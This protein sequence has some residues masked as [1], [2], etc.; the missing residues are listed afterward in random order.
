MARNAFGDEIV[1]AQPVGVNAF[2]DPVLGATPAVGRRAQDLGDA[3]ISGL[4]NSATGLAVRGKLP[5]QQLGEDAPWYHRLASGGAGIVADL[6]LSVAGAAVGAAVGSGVA[7]G[8]G[9][10]VGGGAGAFAAPMAL[11]DALIEAYTYNHALSWEGV[12][13]IGKAA[14][15]G[16]LK[17]AA[18]GGATAG[19]GR[20]VAPLVAGGPVAKGVAAAGAE[21]ATLTATSAALEGHMPTWQDF[22]DNAVLLG[23]MKAAVGTAMKLRSIYAETGKRPE[24][25]FGDAQRDPKL[26]AELAEI[27][28][29][30]V[31]ETYRALAL[32]QRIKA[33]VDADQTT[34]AIR[35][36]LAPE[37]K[38]PP[39]TGESKKEPVAWEYVVDNATLKGVIREVSA[40]TETQIKEQTRGVVTNKMSQAEALKNIATGEVFQHMTGEAG[41]SAQILTAAMLLKSAANKVVLERNKIKDIPEAELALRPDL[42][43]G[44]LAAIENMAMVNA[45]FAGIRAEAGRALQILRAVKSD[46]S[47]VVQADALLKAAERKGTFQDLLAA[48]DSLKDPAQ[49]ARFAKGYT[50]ATT[51]Q[52]FIEA[53]RAGLFSGPV[54]WQANV[55]GNTAK[56]AVDTVKAPIA[57]GVEGVS[58]AAQGDPLSMAQLKARAFAPWYGLQLAAL[59]GAHLAGQWNKIAQEKGAIAGAKAVK[60]DISAFLE[61]GDAKM[62]ITQRAN[63]GA[64][65]SFVGF[66]FGMLKLQDLPFRTVGERAKAYVMAVDRVSAE[67]LHPNS[68]EFREAVARYVDNPTLG[69]SEKA[70]AK[71]LSKIERAGSEAVFSEQLGPRTAQVSG[72]MSGTPWEFIFPARRTPVNLL[73]WAVQHTPGLN[74]MS[75]RWREDYK[76]GGERRAAATA[77]VVVGT[78]L[79]ATAFQMAQDGSLTGGGLFDKEMAGTKAGAKVQNYS[80][81]VGDTYYSIQR[82]EPV[83]K[84]LMLTAD[85]VEITKSSKVEEDKKKAAAM[86]A[87]AFANATVSTTYLSGLANVMKAATDPDRYGEQFVESY[88]TTIV[89]KTIGQ[90]APLLDPY[91]REVDGVMDAIQSQIPFLREKLLPKR[92]VWGEPQSNDR[93]FD[94]MPI[95]TTEASKEKVRTEALRLQIGIADAPRYVEERGPFKSRDRRTELTPEQRDI[96]RDVSG[97][98]AM[99]ILGPIVNAPDWERIPDFAQIA[100]YKRVIQDARKQ[101]Q[102]KA[103]PPDSAE[104]QA[105]IQKNVER[106]IKE[107][108]EAETRS[109]APQRE[110]IYVPQSERRVR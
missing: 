68:R 78:A 92:D 77:R 55:L 62:D 80:I 90:T 37:T 35:R 27:A 30:D 83:A 105:V 52:K 81:R 23:G 4:Q 19:A 8:A 18:I 97:K 3:I 63:T 71:V 26:K 39:Q 107:T 48:V 31:P 65:G 75:T 36:N 61:H 102:N 6:P 56:W 2:G 49:M 88:A 43:L 58:R 91:K 76:A 15:K 50:E 38:E 54:T 10:V 42:K 69:L 9:T 47:M 87:L 109:P 59:D 29:G 57:A 103:L 41:N 51:F 1:E 86:L 99:A 98:Q 104:R 33:A 46:P 64:V 28:S 11:R 44:V 22:M 110:T 82:I 60:G 45:E 79:A 40:L 14:V 20:V 5:S 72:A 24:E 100:I 95:T 12:W 70:A 21:L 94:V 74:L 85:L 7:P 96:F 34:E 89:P 106:I 13:E 25:V 53:W 16:G 73:D 17:G 66:S 84:L 93:W 101:G 108:Q 32:E 67:G